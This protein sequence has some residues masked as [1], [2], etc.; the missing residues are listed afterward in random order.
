MI[1]TMAPSRG[2]I[3]TI[4]VSYKVADVGTDL[5]DAER[6]KAAWWHSKWFGLK[7]HFIHK[8]QREDDTISLRQFLH[9]HLFV[10]KDDQSF[11]VR[12][13]FDLFF[14]QIPKY[15]HGTRIKLIQEFYQEVHVH[16]CSVCK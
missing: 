9:F 7:R 3:L 12:A 1:S 16:P 6:T 14:G 4:I 11:K 2:V 15:I 5:D 10:D 8:I 13:S